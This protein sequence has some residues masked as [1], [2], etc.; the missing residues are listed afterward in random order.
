MPKI[1]I[2]E[3]EI[4]RTDHIIKSIVKK[5]A[6]VI[7]KDDVISEVIEHID[8]VEPVKKKELG[9]LAVGTVKWGPFK[10][11]SLPGFTTIIVLNSGDYAQLGPYKLKD[12]KGRIMENLWQFSKC[13]P[14]VE[15]IE[16]PYSWT[17]EGWGQRI[18]WIHPKEVH[19]D[20]IKKEPTEQF[21]LWR[22]KGFNNM[23]PVRSPVPRNKRKTCLFSVPLDATDASI[24]YD[25]IEARKKIYCPLYSKLVHDQPL[26]HKLLDRLKEGENLLI[27]EVDGPI[28]SSLS[29]Y[30]KKYGVSSDF[31]KH[32]TMLVNDMNINVM[33][34]DDKHPFGHS[35]ALSWCL[36][37]DLYK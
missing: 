16:S 12:E 36:Y 3:T 31:I 2:V 13:Y 8:L 21:W 5:K 18:V 37:Q 28:E 34:N 35:L 7:Y 9:K 17:K 1:R 22:E 19:Y 4:E 32:D 25:Y 24:R 29:Y 27:A 14:V 26:Y 23:E 15:Y 10:T 20:P 30:K 33:L 6:T 11:P